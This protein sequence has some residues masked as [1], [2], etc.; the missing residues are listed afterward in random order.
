MKGIINA[1]KRSEQ[2]GLLIVLALIIIS[3][4]ALEPNFFRLQNFINILFSASIVGLIV[5]GEALLIIG[6]QIDL[7]PGAV[8][9]FSGVLAAILLGKSLPLLVVVIIV[10]LVA[11]TIGLFNSQLVNFLKIEPFI[12]TLATMSVFRGLAYIVGGGTAVPIRHKAFI[13]FGVGRVF[14][15][16]ISVIFFAVIAAVFLVILSRTR[17]GRNVYMIGGNETAARLAGLNPK[18]IKVVLYTISTVLASCGGMILAGRMNS[19]Q[20]VAHSG[21]EFDALTIAILGGVRFVGG[22]GTLTGCMTA[23]F[24]VESFKNGLLVLNVPV[25]WQQVA[26]GV[27]LIV[28]LS[29]DYIRNIQREK[30]KDKN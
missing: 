10:L 5:I 27:M 9:A 23:L 28:A 20:P 7:S 8:A 15:I 19:G 25:F 30:Q 21:L 14:G 17:F 11:V 18:R 4:T 22:V 24:I 16:P 1:I 6:G 3:F 12:A 26:R 13:Y 2:I 29:V